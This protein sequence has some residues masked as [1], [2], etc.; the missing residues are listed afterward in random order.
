VRFPTKADSDWQP[1]LS[2]RR[3]ASSRQPPPSANC[4]ALDR[5]PSTSL[6]RK[7]AAATSRG[8][9]ASFTRAASYPLARS[10]S[11]GSLGSTMGS[12]QYTCYGI[13]PNPPPQNTPQPYIGQNSTD[14]APSRRPT[15]QPTDS[16]PPDSPRL[17]AVPGGPLQ[18]NSLPTSAPIP[19]Q[20]QTAQPGRSTSS[21]V[22]AGQGRS[23]GQAVLNTTSASTSLPAGAA[24]QQG[25]NGEAVP[26][27]GPSNGEAVPRAGP[28]TSLL[29]DS[30][31]LNSM[32]H[33]SVAPGSDA[34]TGSRASG[35]PASTATTWLHS[36]SA[37]QLSINVRNLAA[38]VSLSH[39]SW[40]HMLGL[41]LLVWVILICADPRLIAQSA[42]LF[43]HMS[44]VCM[45]SPSLRTNSLGICKL[46]TLPLVGHEASSCDVIHALHITSEHRHTQGPASWRI[47]RRKVYTF[48]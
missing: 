11:T 21:K 30:S 44:D 37:H 28:A 22:R 34:R 25:G 19:Q 7:H 41:L 12:P 33:S 6:T 1:P 48:W 42:L 8:P 2:P 40:S 31:V 39:D 26:R 10:P 20:Q 13:S 17:E 47:E 29:A 3:P 45:G 9:A 23:S 4:P 36:H 38:Q 32:G 14:Q 35:P 5:P 24:Q 18:P 16:A 43:Y 15:R 46:C 27:A